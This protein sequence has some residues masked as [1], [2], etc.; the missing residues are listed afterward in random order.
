MKKILI[1]IILC[2]C[3]KNNAQTILNVTTLAQQQNQWCWAGSTKS[4]MDYYGTVIPQCQIAE[5]TRT[6]ATW[7]NYGS[8]NCC[9]DPSVGCNYWNYSWGYSGS[10]QDI[11]QTLG[12]INNYGVGSDLS[13]GQINTEITAGRPFI[14]RWGWA[15]GGGHFIVGKGIDVGNNIYYMNPWPGEG[16]KVSTYAWMQTDGDHTWTHTNLITTNPPPI[17]T[18]LAAQKNTEAALLIFPNPAKDNITV[19]FENNAVT[20]AYLY[21]V[22]G[23]VVFENDFRS[24]TNINTEGLSRG[25]YMLKV[26]TDETSLI[27]KVVLN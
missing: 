17:S 18:N 14:I 21:D 5:Y 11:L 13:I 4:I 1:I 27:R 22:T 9:T 20:K 8:T 25:I 26:V 23:R 7:H 15:A 3:L 16:S 24:S 10:M 2:F 19:Q 6:T 12:S